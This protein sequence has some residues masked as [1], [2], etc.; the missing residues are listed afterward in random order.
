MKR[1]VSLSIPEVDVR[2]APA[3]RRIYRGKPQCDL[4]NGDR[5]MT[6]RGATHKRILRT[7]QLWQ[8][9][10]CVIATVSLDRAFFGATAAYSKSPDPSGFDGPLNR[11]VIVG[12]IRDIIPIISKD[13][14]THPMLRVTYII[15]VTPYVML[16]PREIFKIWLD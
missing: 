14:R 11:T 15:I 12:P 5:E 2:P 16:R 13:A 3:G 8:S 1:I 6:V 9:V 10:C 4:S 7:N